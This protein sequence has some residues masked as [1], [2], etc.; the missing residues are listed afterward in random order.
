MPE[1]GPPYTI[2][3]TNVLLGSTTVHLSSNND[4]Y[5]RPIWSEDGSKIAF[6]IFTSVEEGDASLFV[7]ELKSGS[8]STVIS[9]ERGER[10]KSSAWLSNNV[11]AYIREGTSQSAFSGAQLLTIRADGSDQYLIDEAGDL[12]DLGVV[13]AP[14][15]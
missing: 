8:V 4:R 1:V 5:Q 9:G 2:N 10:I 7:L 15:Q 14:A 3:S 6:T 11:I 12:H 13:Q